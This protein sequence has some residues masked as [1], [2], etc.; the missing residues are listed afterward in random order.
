MS[1]VNQ[2]PIPPREMALLGGIHLINRRKDGTHYNEEMRIFPV[3]GAT[4]ET[5]GYIAIKRT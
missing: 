2:L 1:Q 3:R 4:G 5:V